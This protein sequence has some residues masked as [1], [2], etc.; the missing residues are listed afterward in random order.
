MNDGEI[1][2]S[3]T[4]FFWTHFKPESKPMKNTVKD[5]RCKIDT[6]LHKKGEITCGGSFNPANYPDV[7]EL[8]SDRW[9]PKDGE[10]YW[11]IAIESES[12]S[13]E[14]YVKSYIWKSKYED[15]IS[16]KQNRVFRTKE[17]AEEVLKKLLQVLLD[18]HAMMLKNMHKASNDTKMDFKVLLISLAKTIIAYFKK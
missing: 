15:K 3:V 8:L 14:F 18:A 5:Y 17:K 13:I 12:G 7:Y 2:K 6:P 16:L 4:D 9:V 1:N 10:E 11:E